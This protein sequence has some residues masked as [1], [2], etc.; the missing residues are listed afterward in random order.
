MNKNILTLF[1]GLLAFTLA[2]DAQSYTKKFGIEVNGGLREYHGDLGSAAYFKQTPDYQGIGGGFGMYLNPSFDLNLYGSTGDIGFYKTTYDDV[3]V[4]NYRQGFRSRVTE[5][6]IG[7]TYKFNNGYIIAEDARF[8]PFLRLGI[9]AMQSISKFTEGSTRVGDKDD[10]WYGS[11]NRTWIASHWNAGLGLKIKLSESLDLVISEQF[12]YTFDDNYDASPYSLAGARLNVAGEGN[13]PLHDIYLYHSVGFVFNF[14]SNGNSG[15]YTI[16]DSDNDG[17]SDDFDICPETPEGYAVDTVGCPYDR[18][19]DGIIDEEDKCPDE[20]GT[21][22][23]GGCPDTDADGIQDSEDKCPNVPGIIEFAGCPDSDKDNIQDSEDKCPLKPGTAEGEG[24]PDSDGDG[25][26][27][28]LDVCP[29]TPGLASNK[30]CPEIK[31]EVKEQIRL[32]A[33]GIFFES[34]KEVIKVESFTNLDKL[35]SIMNT[36]EEANVMIEGHTDSQGEDADN[37]LLSQE[38]ADAVKRYLSSQGVADARMTAVG[39]GE[40]K[41]IADN[42]S[43]EGRVLNRRVDFKLV[44]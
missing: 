24:C 32:A 13:K 17:I 26:Y 16:K 27:D 30:G 34:G 40:T 22:A 19:S 23:F 39:Y 21:A 3:R 36:F 41:P 37:M 7:V 8:K 35:A 44:Y 5:G 31:E 2:A 1:I 20:A 38:R 11:Q 43:A 25:V 28:H 33:K 29:A 14:G 9:G 18:D 42:E 4:E 10:Y 15:R 12:N 6:M